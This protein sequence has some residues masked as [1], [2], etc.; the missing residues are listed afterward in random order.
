M[1]GR[2]LAKSLL[3]EPKTSLK[4]SLGALVSGNKLR[5]SKK[6]FTFSN[7]LSRK[8]L[9]AHH[10]PPLLPRHMGRASAK[11]ARVLPQA[12]AALRHF[13]LSS[14]LCAETI[15]ATWE[16]RSENNMERV[17]A[18]IAPPSYLYEVSSARAPE[19]FHSVKR[20]RKGRIFRW[21]SL[22][23]IRQV[24]KNRLLLGT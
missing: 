2:I 24:I 8:P 3:P 19:G 6:K 11:H 5:F 1:S 22:S 15:G 18:M 21:I 13:T 14:S 17:R 20:S 23:K 9:E 4:C 16:V 12:L 10:S 7:S